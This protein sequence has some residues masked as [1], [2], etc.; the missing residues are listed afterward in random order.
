M[1][2]PFRMTEAQRE[3]LQR[4]TEIQL[5]PDQIER[6]AELQR[7]REART[8]NNRIRETKRAAEIKARKARKAA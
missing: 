1:Y 6:L 4:L 7:A 5:R 8:E 3:G 2:D